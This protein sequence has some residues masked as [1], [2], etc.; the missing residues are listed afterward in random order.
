M[1]NLLVGVVLLSLSVLVSCVD[2]FVDAPDLTFTEQLEQ[3]IE[4]IDAFLSQ[5]DIQAIEHETGI[6]YVM[7]VEGTGN[8][9]ELTDDITVTYEG[10][11]FTGGIFDSNSDGITFPLGQLIEAWRISI[12]LMKEGGSMT[13]YA[14][15]GYCY[16]SQGVD[17]VIPANSNL[18]FDIDLIEVVD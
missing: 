13:I 1:R 3:D 6:R 8:N 11:F 4:F 16:G 7:N 18:I 10:R 12:P 15:S 5:N 17:G 14:P 9:P 2:D